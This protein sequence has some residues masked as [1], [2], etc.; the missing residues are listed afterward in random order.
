MTATLCR[1]S[2][3]LSQHTILKFH[4]I[5]YESVT[6]IAE[7][8]LSQQARECGSKFVRAINA[9]KDISRAIEVRSE[10]CGVNASRVHLPLSW[11]LV[12]VWFSPFP[13]FPAGS[14]SWVR[15]PRS[16]VNV[17][18]HQWE[19]QIP[20]STAGQPKWKWCSVS[21]PP[22]SADFILARA[23]SQI[24]AWSD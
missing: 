10:V 12:Q 2:K 23:R 4:G 9:H 6:E 20:H 11:V 5:K 22:H 8:I 14:V 18:Q 19:W 7:G 1:I 16:C 24:T 13:Q 17:C 21:D 3:N 15:S